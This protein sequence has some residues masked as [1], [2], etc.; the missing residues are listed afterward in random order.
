MNMQEMLG[1]VMPQRS[2]SR[3][4]PI[5]EAR[6]ILIQE[7]LQEL[8]YVDITPERWQHAVS[9]CLEKKPGQPH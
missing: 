3:K 6:E 2:K 7:E 4:M 8:T 9:V 1:R 5:R